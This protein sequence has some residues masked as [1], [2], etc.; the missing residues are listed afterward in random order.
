VLPKNASDADWGATFTQ[1]ER[2]DWVFRLGNLTLLQKGPNGRIGNKPFTI[3]QPVLAASA[4]QLT[5]EIGMLP[6]WTPT[7]I[8]NRQE[9]LAQLAVKVWP[10]KP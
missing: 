4:F 9:G 2:K 7:G 10:R 3:K 6:D 1:D 5:K 8:K